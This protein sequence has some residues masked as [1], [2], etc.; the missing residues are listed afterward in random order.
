LLNV[1][2]YNRVAGLPYE[3]PTNTAKQ[4]FMQTLTDA[5]INVQIRERK[6]DEINAACGQL[7]RV[8]NDGPE[9]VQLSLP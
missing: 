7:R 4:R 8:L 3:E 9:L 5:G 6:G 2:P 1:I